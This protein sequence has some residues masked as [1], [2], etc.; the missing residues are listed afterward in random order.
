VTRVVA[1]VAFVVAAGL[2][3]VPFILGH[4]DC[5][6]CSTDAD[7]RAGRRC[8]PFSDGQ[9]RCVSR[10]STCRPGHVTTGSTWYHIGAIAAA[11]VGAYAWWFSRAGKGAPPAEG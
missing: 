3:S 2:F 4:D 8:R 1:I 10:E 9:N 5:A 6:E 11:L 7:C